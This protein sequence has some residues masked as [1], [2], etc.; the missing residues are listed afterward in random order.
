MKRK[1]FLVGILTICINFISCSDKPSK[2]EIIVIENYT[3]K[4]NHDSLI[5][6]KW[7]PIE[8]FE[9]KGTINKDY[10]DFNEKGVQR[11]RM[12]KDG[13]PF[14]DWHFEH[15]YYTKEGKIYLYKPSEKGFL[16]MD[17]EIFMESEYEISDD[18]KKLTIAEKTYN[19]LE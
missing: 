15:Y 7:I 10:I 3:T 4:E 5:L 6:G 17:S 13:E 1:Y 18:G 8:S 19:R 16:A 2:E 14:N 9:Y 11:K 12:F